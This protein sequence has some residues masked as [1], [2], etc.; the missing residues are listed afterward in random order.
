MDGILLPIT[1]Q[2]KNN[3][4][5]SGSNIQFEMERDIFRLPENQLELEID[6]RDKRLPRLEATTSS[7]PYLHLCYDEYSRSRPSFVI[8]KSAKS[9][10]ETVSYVS[11]AC[12]DTRLSSIN[13]V[14]QS[15]VQTD[16]ATE[17]HRI[18]HHYRPENFPWT[19]SFRKLVPNSKLL[20]SKRPYSDTNL[21]VKVPAVLK[22][23]FEPI[24]GT[25]TLYAIIADTTQN[26]CT[27]VSESFHFDLTPQHIRLKFKEI[28]KV[29]LEDDSAARDSGIDIAT[30]LRSCLFEIPE[31]L[32][33]HDVF[34]VFQLSK[35]LSGD[36]EK[37][38][39]PYISRSYASGVDSKHD[40]TCKRLHMFKQQFGMGVI[41]V[42]DDYGQV[43]LAGKPK[44][45]FT[46]FALRNSL[47]DSTIG[48]VEV[49]FTTD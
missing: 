21:L 7:P 32:R 13:S 27:R 19:S 3:V 22:N 39:A 37:A 6:D 4:Q 18:L 48:Q 42:F 33:R 45:M 36:V 31:G 5:K 10:V 44:M 8:A 24:F 26:Q 1:G 41:R 49:V 14:R 25:F 28:Y 15:L 47:S 23:A 46:L 30:T 38:A 9:I 40:E 20:I 34:L 29:F 2:L 43:G 12:P 35:V 17:R 16:T 11:R